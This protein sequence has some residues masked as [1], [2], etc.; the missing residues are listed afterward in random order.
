MSARRMRCPQ[1]RHAARWMLGEEFAEPGRGQGGRLRFG[2]KSKAVENRSEA[3]TELRFVLT[4]YPSPVNGKGKLYWGSSKT[5]NR[6]IQTRTRTCKVAP[7]ASRGLVREVHKDIRSPGLLKHPKR[8]SSYA[9]LFGNNSFVRACTL[10]RGRTRAHCPS[11]GT[12]GL[13]P[14]PE[15]LPTDGAR[16]GRLHEAQGTRRS[17][18]G[19]APVCLRQLRP[20]PPERLDRCGL[21]RPAE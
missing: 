9:V 13:R 7:R 1:M 17:I 5:P 19:P 11:R 12:A 3:R 10:R 15:Q 4:P 8:K 14:C 16:I 21:H 20:V 18:R 2:G 6:R